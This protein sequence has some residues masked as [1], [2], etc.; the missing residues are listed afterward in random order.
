MIIYID[1]KISTSLGTVYLQ[2]AYTPADFASVLTVWGKQGASYYINTIWIDFVYALSYGFMFTSANLFFLEKK[3]AITPDNATGH[4][5][6]LIAAP[7]C[8][9]IFDITENIFH[10]IILQVT[11]NNTLVLSSFIV[12][13]LKWIFLMFSLGTFLFLYFGYRKENR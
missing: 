3:Y 4:F 9:T 2:L 12:S 7:L 6:L 11:I 5:K 13:M 8:A 10:L 1:Q